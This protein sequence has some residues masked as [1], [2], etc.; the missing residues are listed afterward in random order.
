MYDSKLEYRFGL[1][2]EDLRD[3]TYKEALYLKL[4]CAEALLDILFEEQQEEF[5][6]K[7]RIK[8]VMEAIDTTRY[9][10]AEIAK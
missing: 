8:A 10:L 4:D 2:A 3:E 6:D 7:K 1:Q 5:R 9:L